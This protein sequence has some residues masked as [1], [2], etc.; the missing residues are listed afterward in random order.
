MMTRTSVLALGLAALTL[1]ACEKKDEA[2]PSPPAAIAPV[3]AAAT[4]VDQAIGCMTYLALK[5]GAL[6]AAN[7]A[8]D[9]TAVRAALNDWEGRALTFMGP[10]RIS[11]SYA[12]TLA[13]ENKADPAVVEATS[14]WCIAN[15]PKA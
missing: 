4:D 8:S 2:P 3:V 12:S 14:A 15:A 7:A 11:Q 9:V 1:A 10:E 13:V 6:E 5:Q